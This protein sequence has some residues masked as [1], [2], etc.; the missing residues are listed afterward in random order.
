MYEL[1]EIGKAVMIAGAFLAMLG[2][3]MTCADPLSPHFRGMPGD[4]IIKKQNFTLYIPI[5]S[6]LF[7]SFILS[8]IFWFIHKK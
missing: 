6:S 5:I 8:A 1:K 4:I 3:L 7:L 2:L